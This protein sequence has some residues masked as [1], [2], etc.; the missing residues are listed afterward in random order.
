MLELRPCNIELE[1]RVPD[2]PAANRHAQLYQSALGLFNAARRRGAI[3]Q[4]R[5]FLFSHAC[6]LLNLSALPADQVRGRHYGGIRGVNINQ[7]CGTIDRTGD[8][9]H[10]FHPLSDRLRDRWVSVAMAR[11]EGAALPAVRLVQV[12]DCYFVEDGHHRLSVARALGQACIDAEIT[13]WDVNGPLPWAAPAR[14]SAA[15][16]TL[17][18]A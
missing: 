4:I 16:P 13:V 7:I 15:Q 3:E 10:H 1:T 9:D 17:R 5:Q 12:G 2:R 8:F 14:R 18:P 11:V 6:C